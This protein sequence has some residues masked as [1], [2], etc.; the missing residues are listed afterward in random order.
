M[1]LKKVTSLNLFVKQQYRCH[2]CNHIG[3]YDYEHIQFHG[4]LIEK[5]WETKSAPKHCEKCDAEMDYGF[6]AGRNSWEDD[7]S[8]VWRFYLTLICI[9][10]ILSFYLARA[11]DIQVFEELA[12]FI[13]G[14]GYEINPKE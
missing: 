9:F 3:K 5:P 12:R 14:E 6:G 7:W 1:V 10:V 4:K 8:G 13:F 11:H 2:K